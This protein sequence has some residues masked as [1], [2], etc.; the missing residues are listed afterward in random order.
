MAFAWFWHHK[1]LL[2]ILG[3]PAVVVIMGILERGVRDPYN[4]TVG[5]HRILAVTIVKAG[6]T[7]VSI[8]HCSSD[9]EVELRDEHGLTTAASIYGLGKSEQRPGIVLLHGNTALGRNQSTYKVLASKLAD[10][11]YV[12]LTLDLPGFGESDDPFALRRGEAI[13]E[14]KMVRAAIRYLTTTTNVDKENLS[15]IGHSRGRAAAL[16]VAV[17]ASDIRNIIIMGV[18]SHWVT[19]KTDEGPDRRAQKTYQFVYGHPMPGWVTADIWNKHRVQADIGDYAEYFGRQGHKPIMIIVGERERMRTTEMLLGKEPSELTDKAYEYLEQTY[20]ALAKP[21][22]FVVIRRSDHYFNSAQ[23]L[24]LTVYDKSVMAQ[25]ISEITA[26]L[27][28][29]SELATTTHKNS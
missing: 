22:H 17:N 15:I 9:R 18:S 29:Q 3:I 13:D 23:S 6:L 26:W 19:G 24:G 1:I 11:G 25:L 5:P 28:P 10:S 8:C 2:A 14:T 21:K 27:S 7:N 4:R 12:V 16:K 20:A